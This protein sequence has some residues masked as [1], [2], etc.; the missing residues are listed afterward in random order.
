MKEHDIDED[1]I[2]K[3]QERRDKAL[4][5]IKGWRKCKPH[6]G[7]ISAVKMAA[8][9]FFDGGKADADIAAPAWIRI[10]AIKGSKSAEAHIRKIFSLT[11]QDDYV[12]ELCTLILE[13]V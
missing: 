6:A 11:P 5:A 8:R 10:A 4:L 13:Q 12:S 7:Q 9:E 1:E 3:V 2:L